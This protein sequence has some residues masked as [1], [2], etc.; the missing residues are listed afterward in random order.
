MPTT[1]YGRRVTVEVAGLS[2]GA[3]MQDDPNALRIAFRVD[4]EPDETEPTAEIRLYNLDRTH[5]TQIRDRGGPVVLSAGY[6]GALG[7][8]YRGFVERAQTE[9]QDVE[10]V[11]TIEGAGHVQSPDRLGGV[12]AFS[13]AGDVQVSQIASDLIGAMGLQA[14][15]LDA[16]T[17]TVQNFAWSGRIDRALTVVLRRAGF[18]WYDDDGVVKVARLAGLSAG[19]APALTLSVPEGL[20]GSPELTEDGATA[21]SLLRPEARI[22]MPVQVDSMT[23]TGAWVVAGLRHEG[24]SRGQGHFLTHYELRPR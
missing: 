21:S 23:L 24:D 16:V 1:R 4:R 13:Y 5:A 6:Q 7:E 8:L 17:G 15:P 10:R 11:T 19:D 3:A 18:A 9:R 14:G 2:L 22:G 20:V 12:G